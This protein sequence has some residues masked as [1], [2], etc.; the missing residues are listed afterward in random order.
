VYKIEKEIK[1]SAIAKE[2]D[3]KSF[4]IGFLLA[5]VIL[6]SLGSG[7]ASSGTQDVRIV[8]INTSDKLE[9]TIADIGYSVKVPVVIKDQPVTVTTR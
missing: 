9:V 8:D 2:I 3:F 1:M 6:L 4:L 5:M 7:P